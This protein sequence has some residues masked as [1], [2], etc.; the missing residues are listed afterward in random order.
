MTDRSPITINGRIPKIERKRPSRV[1][2]EN[3]SKGVRKF[4]D[5]MPMVERTKRGL[6]LENAN[7]AI[8]YAGGTRSAT[9]VSEISTPDNCDWFIETKV[10]ALGI[11]SG[12]A[13]KLFRAFPYYCSAGGRDQIGF[14]HHVE[15]P[16]SEDRK[17]GSNR[18]TATLSPV[19]LGELGLQTGQI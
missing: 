13:N 16:N 14:D 6:R 18:Y 15:V 1:Y 19:Q 7:L 10:E 5:E 9:V 12:S 8:P 4:M 11:E 3:G 17:R 2:I